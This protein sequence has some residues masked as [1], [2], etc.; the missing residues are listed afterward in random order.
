MRA[1]NLESHTAAKK[2][3]YAP[4]NP[5][6]R[7]NE[8]A[9]DSEGLDGTTDADELTLL[10]LGSAEGGCFA[11]PIL[12]RGSGWQGGCAPHVRRNRFHLC[13]EHT[14]LGVTAPRV[15]FQRPQHHF[16]QSHINLHL[17]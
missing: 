10:L 3:Q 14:S 8:K 9:C 12:R 6:D 2:Q 13:F 5:T 11:G 17:L 7:R 16:V 4:Q 1:E 15:F